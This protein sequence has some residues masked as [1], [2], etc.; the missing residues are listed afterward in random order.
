MSRALALAAAVCALAAAPAD[1]RSGRVAA[2]QVAL[3]AHGLYA[4]DVDGLAGPETDAAIRAFQ[5]RARL[6][7]D[8]IA[9]PDTR[10]ALGRLGR[11]PYG[12][13]ALVP[14]AVGWDVSVLQFRMALRGF[15]GGAF[16][17]G[18][19]PRTAAAVRALQAS[20]GLLADGV[21]G[22]ATWAALR[23]APPRSPIALRRPVAA[24]A[25]GGFGPRGAAMHTGLDF[26]APSG[27]PVAA[28]ASGTAVSV[29]FADGYGRLVVLAHGPGVQTWYAH[30]SATTVE[31][32]QAVAA[33]T[34]IGRVG[35]TGRATGPHLHFELRVRGAAIDPLPAIGVGVR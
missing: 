29:G 24:P 26:P 35:A 32:G 16:D 18:Y 1:A 5:R 11:H 28:A 12:S 21:A 15:A 9:G 25:T 27:T 4:G 7:V 23:R 13:R 19:G 34:R 10:R 3:R 8:G 14:G 20:A 17:G 33:G 22:P 30:L 31:P 6:L 2:L